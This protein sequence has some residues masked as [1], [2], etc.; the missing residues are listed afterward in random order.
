MTVW[1]LVQI[2]ETSPKLVQQQ[3]FLQLWATEPHSTLGGGMRYDPAK[4][5]QQLKMEKGPE[6]SGASV[7][8]VRG[9]LESRESSMP[10]DKCQ[11]SSQIDQRRP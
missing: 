8:R 6:L 7:L 4:V 11:Q 5:L 1:A 10:S 9:A 3:R 2:A